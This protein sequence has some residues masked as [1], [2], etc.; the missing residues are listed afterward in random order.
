MQSNFTLVKDVPMILRK[1]NG[2]NHNK[3]I[4]L[5]YRETKNRGYSLYLD[6]WKNNKREYKFLGIY[7][8]GKQSTVADDKKKLKIACA[9][10]DR[11]D[12]ELFEKQT[13]FKLDNSKQKSNFIDYFDRI[14]QKRNHHNWRSCLK[15]LKDYVGNN[16]SFQEIDENFCKRFKEYL[17][18]H[19]GENTTKSYFDIFKAILNIAKKDR[20]IPENPSQNIILRLKET[21]RQFLTSEELEKLLN[22]PSLDREVK[23]AFLFSCF[24]GLRLS[25]VKDLTFDQINEGYLI[26]RQNKTDNIIRTKLPQ[27]ALDI[28]EEQKKKRKHSEDKIVFLLPLSKDTINKV[29]RRWIKDAEINKHITFH[30]AR[31]T[32]ATLCLTYDID[33]YT[34]SKLLGHRDI[35]TTQI[36]AK[37]IDKKKDEAIGKLPFIKQMKIAEPEES[38]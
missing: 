13:G 18:C 37:I 34:T 22:T 6:L 25:D 5:R 10:R 38:K 12:I 1:L 27:N 28:I 26:V 14:A 19:V 30:C 3:T 17:L 11:K 15:H 33:L 29:I 21:T 16:L 2:M 4:K 35:S 23:N 9:I 31:H 20:I 24:T 7:I 8:Q 36:Y 32:F